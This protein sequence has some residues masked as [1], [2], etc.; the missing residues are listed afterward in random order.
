MAVWS[1]GILA[2]TAASLDPAAVSR[3]LERAERWASVLVGLRGEADAR[4]FAAAPTATA[5][6]AVRTSLGRARGAR[7]AS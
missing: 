4:T 3:L 7:W 6:A 2:D 5:T 1:L